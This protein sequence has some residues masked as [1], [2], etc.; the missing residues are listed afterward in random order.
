MSFNCTSAQ[1]TAELSEDEKTRIR[2]GIHLLTYD[3][4][5][6]FDNAVGEAYYNLVIYSFKENL[7]IPQ[8][9]F[10]PFT[11]NDKS[12]IERIIQQFNQL[13][14]NP[15]LWDDLLIKETQYMIWLDKV[16]H[17]KSKYK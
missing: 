5:G 6:T 2:F 16:T 13:K 17:K 10:S 12:K 1:S 11:V 15:P 8:F 9:S 7:T 3:T 14:M 4:V